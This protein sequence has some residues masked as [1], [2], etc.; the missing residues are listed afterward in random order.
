MYISVIDNAHF[1]MHRCMQIWNSNWFSINSPPPLKFQPKREEKI[2][3]WEK[4]YFKIGTK[5][6][7]SKF[8]GGIATMEGGPNIIYII[9]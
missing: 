2:L 1:F 7:Y 6:L 3:V 5:Q 8:S 4:F 9:I